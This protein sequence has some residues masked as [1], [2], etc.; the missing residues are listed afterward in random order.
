MATYVKFVIHTYNKQSEVLAVF[1]RHSAEVRR[2]YQGVWVRGCYAHNGQHGECY[3]GMQRRK[4][5]TPK[6]YTPLLKELE[7]IGY[8]NLVVMNKEKGQEHD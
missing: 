6:Q 5:A 4:A 1:M 7:S 3:D 8:D 2:N